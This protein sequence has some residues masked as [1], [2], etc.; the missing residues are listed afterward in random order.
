[1][2]AAAAAAGA[3][4]LCKLQLS[5]LVETEDGL[6]SSELTGG[7]VLNSEWRAARAACCC[8]ICSVITALL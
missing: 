1:V 5:G 6:L 8:R 7:E 4:R 2:H 3:S